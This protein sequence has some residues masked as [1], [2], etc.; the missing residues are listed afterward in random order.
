[1]IMAGERKAAKLVT[2]GL[3]GQLALK[4]EHLPISGV[5]AL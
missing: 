3:I 4:L 5:E 1:M 2:V